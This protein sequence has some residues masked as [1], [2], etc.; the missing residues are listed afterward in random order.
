MEE[1]ENEGAGQGRM[2]STDRT[3]GSHFAALWTFGS[4][5]GAGGAFSC[6]SYGVRC[7]ADTAA[8]LVDRGSEV[9]D[10]LAQELGDGLI[11]EPLRLIAWALPQGAGCPGRQHETQTAGLPVFL[12]A[13][14]I[15]SG[16][17]RRSGT[18]A[19]AAFTSGAIDPVQVEPGRPPR[20]HAARP[21]LSPAGGPLAP[22]ICYRIL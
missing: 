10:R 14:V 2:D 4:T 1:E 3:G 9:R 5:W 20:A 8:H 12:D 6:P 19:L 16:P 18:R 11:G 13:R 21:I 7:I 15:H 17:P 22:R